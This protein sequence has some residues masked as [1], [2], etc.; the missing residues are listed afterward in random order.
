LLLAASTA[1]ASS[2]C[3]IALIV[4][5]T[6]DDDDECLD[7]CECWGECDPI[8]EPTPSPPT[9]TISIPDWPPLGPDG[10]VTVEAATTNTTLSRATFWFLEQHEESFSGGTTGTVRASGADLGEGLGT[11]T[12]EV[13]TAGGAWT[14]KEVTDLLVDLSAPTAYVDDTVLPAA[15]AD[16]VFWIAD[17][18]VVSGY[19]L[20]VAGKT[21]TETLEPGYPSTLGT[22]WDYSLVTIPVTEFPT[23]VFV[24]ELRVFDAAGNEATIELPLTIDGIPPTAGIQSP[25]QGADVTGAFP[26]QVTGIDD[27]PGNVSLELTIGGALVATANGPT[28]GVVVDAN[29]FPAGP[30]D[31]TVIAVDEAGNKSAPSTHTV[32]VIHP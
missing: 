14:K 28:A 31:I 16:L 30:I 1:S 5:A 6:T 15:G 7:A 20:T 13:R 8:Q 11:L 9:V 12:V 23:G 25:A 24:G 27:L 32:N 17:A 22:D 26:I 3:E 18:W 10:E 4:A 29:E 2:G 19:E 21:F